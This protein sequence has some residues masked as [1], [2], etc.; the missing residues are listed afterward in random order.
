MNKSNCLN[1]YKLLNYK[2]NHIIDNNDQYPFY[3]T[4]V[5]LNTDISINIFEI[6]EIE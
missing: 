4:H 1:K 3:S 6:E 2:L 5:S